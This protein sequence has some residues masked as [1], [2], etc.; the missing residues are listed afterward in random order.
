MPSALFLLY[1]GLVVNNFG[2]PMTNS[3]GGE[4]GSF[5]SS[6]GRRKESILERT[7]GGFCVLNILLYPLK[8]ASDAMYEG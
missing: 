6:F 8:R 3:E 5:L 2:E 7:L 1:F 4:V